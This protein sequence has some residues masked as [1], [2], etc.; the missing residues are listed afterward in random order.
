[1]YFTT[2]DSFIFQCHNADI[3][4]NRNMKFCSHSNEILQNQKRQ[5]THSTSLSF[6]CMK[7]KLTDAA[8][9]YL[10]VLCS[11]WSWPNTEQIQHQWSGTERKCEQF[12]ACCTISS[13]LIVP[14]NSLQWQG[15]WFRDYAVVQTGLTENRWPLAHFSTNFYIMMCN[16]LTGYC[17]PFKQLIPPNGHSSG[18]WKGQWTGSDKI[19]ISTTDGKYTCMTYQHDAL[20]FPLFCY[21]ASTRFGLICSPSSR[22]QVY[23]IWQSYWLFF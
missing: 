12:I 4:W 1:M 3:V 17:M 5:K 2:T 22:G 19:L 15:I 13:F 10:F 14:N 7:C 23:I 18:S 11:W 20:F 8:M 6:Q 9:L 21:H 16:I